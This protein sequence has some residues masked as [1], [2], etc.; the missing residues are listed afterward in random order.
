MSNPSIDPAHLNE[1]LVLRGIHVTLTD[2]LR[3][4]VQQK[5]EKLFR[6]EPQI[7]RVRVDIEHD[8]TKA[9]GHNFIAKGHIE[10]GGPDLIA[11]VS[12]EDAY[13]SI[14]LLV[15]KL[16]EMLR[17]RADTFHSDKRHGSRAG[18]DAGATEA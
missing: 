16:N 4:S 18:R 1:K 8:K 12:S 17:R 7:V 6:H 10:I 15:D 14:D 2:A 5:A 11:S 13:K 3:S 9:I